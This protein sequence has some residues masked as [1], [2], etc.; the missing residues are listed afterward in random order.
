MAAWRCGLLSLLLAP[1]ADAAQYP[2]VWPE[3]Q[4]G[5]EAYLPKRWKGSG[6]STDYHLSGYS[7]QSKVAE[8]TAATFNETVAK[9]EGA[10]VAFC[11]KDTGQTDGLL[12]EFGRLGIEHHNG[13]GRILIGKVDAVK[14]RELAERHGLVHYPTIWWYVDGKPVREYPEDASRFDKDLTDF[15]ARQLAPVAPALPEGAEEAWAKEALQSI[16]LN[17]LGHFE[18]DD[19]PLLRALRR[20]V[21]LREHVSASYTADAAAYAR[22]AQALQVDVG[23]ERP[24]L[25]VKPY[26]ERVVQLPTAELSALPF[27][28]MVAGVGALL[29]QHGLPLLCPFHEAYQRHILERAASL[30]ILFVV[31]LPTAIPTGPLT[32]L[33][34]KYRGRLLVVTV[35]PRRHE[36]ALLRGWL[37][38]DPAISADTS[39]TR[40]FGYRLN[41]GIDQRLYALSGEVGQPV[42]AGS[43][44]EAVLDGSAPSV[45]VTLPNPTGPNLELQ[46]VTPLPRPRRTLRECHVH[47]CAEGEFFPE[48]TVRMGEV[49]RPTRTRPPPAP[50]AR[51]AARP[52]GP[53]PARHD[54]QPATSERAR[55]ARGSTAR[56]WWRATST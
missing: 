47:K 3:G 52:P 38:L 16:E 32:A 9:H 36:T 51:P 12:I 31:G 7:D 1:A 46:D 20:A 45:P 14:E 33:A 40:F 30:P 28:E 11:M 48:H 8:L 42:P 49:R 5:E 27:D 55:P 34:S 44:I 24:L 18:S 50:P 43:F 6:L 13:T 25:L 41:G 54:K 15:M 17:V 29:Q 53:P 37:G 23:T 26:D 22:T 4:P 56:R 39:A 21:L 10:L 19:A 2:T 35:S